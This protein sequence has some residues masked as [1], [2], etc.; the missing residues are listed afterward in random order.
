MRAKHDDAA[1][2]TTDPAV[3]TWSALGL[4]NY[5]GSVWYRANV[6]LPAIPAAKK[7]YLW[8]GATDG[9]VKVFVNGKH[10]TY[11][12]PKGEKVEAFSGYAQPASFDITAALTDTGRAQISLL[13]TR[14]FLNELGTGGLLAAPVIYRDK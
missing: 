11:A 5:M 4:H 8:I 9:R 2:K 6:K 13:C 14:D 12:G 7:V 3:D 1:W 10:I